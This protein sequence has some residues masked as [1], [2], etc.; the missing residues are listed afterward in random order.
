M[1][2]LCSFWC[3]NILWAPL[4]ILSLSFACGYPVLLPH[5]E[6]VGRFKY[7]V[8]CIELKCR[9]FVAGSTWIDAVSCS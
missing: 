9:S 8:E 7:L 1:R 4:V 5:T 6:P 3:H 2:S